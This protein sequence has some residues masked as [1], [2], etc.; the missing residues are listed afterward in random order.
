MPRLV[1]LAVPLAAFLV[2][3]PAARA[4]WLVYIGGGV[5]E[6]KGPWEVRGRMIVFHAPNGNLQSIRA[7]GVDLPASQ[8]LSWA[9]SESRRRSEQPLFGGRLA[10]ALWRGQPGAIPQ[11][12]PCASARVERVLSP[13]TLEVTLGAKR[14]TVHPTGLSAPQVQQRFPQLSWFG[15]EAAVRIGDVVRAGQSVCLIEEAPPLRDPLGHRRVTIALADGRDLAAEAI[16]RGLAVPSL[17]ASPRA[18]RYRALADE[19]RANERGLWGQETLEP[20][21]AVMGNAGILGA[22]PPAFGVSSGVG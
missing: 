11:G 2:L 1:R 21:L 10:G 7:D 18:T 15:H 12:T 6:T 16:G 9:L 13:E 22:G 3:A 17:T 8:F 14:E 20:A 4:D 19:A 5:Q